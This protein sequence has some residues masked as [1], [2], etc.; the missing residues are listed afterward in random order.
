L[1]VLSFFFSIKRDE[2]IKSR[3]LPLP[4]VPSPIPSSPRRRLYPTGW[5]QSRRP[6]GEGK[7]DFQISETPRLKRRGFWLSSRTISSPLMGE[8][9]GGG[10]SS[11]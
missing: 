4:F 3:K 6:P 8:D 7:W 2:H 9:K 1:I 11:F 5:K 10:E